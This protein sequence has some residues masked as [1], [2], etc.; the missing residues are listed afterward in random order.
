MT[1]RY[2]VAM[3]FGAAPY[4]LRKEDLGEMRRHNGLNCLIHPKSDAEVAAIRPALERSNVARPR[5]ARALKRETNA[6]GAAVVGTIAEVDEKPW[7]G[8]T[9]QC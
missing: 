4:R 3:A 7:T 6:A 5:N 2:D 9:P 1:D 8:L